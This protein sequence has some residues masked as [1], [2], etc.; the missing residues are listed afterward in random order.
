MGYTQEE[1]T[2]EYVI[3]EDGTKRATKE[4]RAEKVYPPDMQAL[5]LYLELKE[6]QSSLGSMTDDEL[7]KE[8]NR[9]MK[10]LGERN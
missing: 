2:V 8:K 3:E 4:R 6:E 9:L 7:E 1:R 10:E 5:K